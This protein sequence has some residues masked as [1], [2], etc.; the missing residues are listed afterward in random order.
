MFT[1]AKIKLIYCYLV[2]FFSSFYLVFKAATLTHD[3]LKIQNFNDTYQ[4]PNNLTKANF[5]IEKKNK[6]LNLAKL[7]QL[8]LEAIE[9]NKIEQHKN[10]KNNI[11]L[12][13]PYLLYF[14]FILGIH[15]I[16]IRRTKES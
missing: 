7:E 12:E 14:A 6:C 1:S 16:L 10:L 15:I 5:H 4:I 3:V 2:C 13:L 8:R 9:E 11:I